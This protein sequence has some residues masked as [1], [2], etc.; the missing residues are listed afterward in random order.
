M[1]PSRR[2]LA[3]F[4]A[5]WA[6]LHC[7]GTL[8]AD[9][10]TNVPEAAGYQLVYTL[11]IPAQQGAYNTDAIPYSVNNAGM[12]PGGTFTR[13]A[14]YLEL[15]GSTDPTRPNGY[16]FVSFDRPA[17]FANGGS[18][19]V[20]SNGPNGSKIV[21]NTT[22]VNMNV[23]SNIQ[24]VITGTGLPGGKIE[25]WPGNY[26]VGANGVF[27][28]DDDG[29]NGGN[30][31]G[32]MQ[33]HNA[34]AGQT[35]IGYSDWGGNAPG[36]PSEIG[37]G[38]NTGA[39]DPDWTFSNTGTTYTVRS[40][41]I[42]VKPAANLVSITNP[43]F[44]VDPIAGP[45]APL[46]EFRGAAPTGWVYSGE[47]GQGLLAPDASEPNPFYNGFTPGYSGSKA[48]F[49]YTLST[50]GVPTLSQNLS[51]TLQANTTYGLS[52]QI[53]NR[54]NSDNWGGY[55]IALKTTSGTLV[56]EWVGANN[57]LAPFGQ[58]AR[59]AR[60]FTTGNNPP[61]LGQA[62]Q[63][64]IEQPNLNATGRYLEIDDVLLTAD[65]AP[66]RPAGTPIDVM[67]V[68][69]QSNAQG[70]QANVAALNS[71]NRHYADTPS[72]NAFIAYKQNAFGQ[73]LYISG[74]LGQLSSLGAGFAGNFDGFGPE[75]STGTDLAGRLPNKVAVI[76]FASGG[77][78]L[79]NHFKKTANVLYADLMATVNGGLAQLTAQGFAPTVKG[80]FW[81]QG[82]TDAL[83]GGTDATDAA[84][85]GANITQFVADVRADLGVPTLKFILTQI[86]PNM[87]AL[88]NQPGV[89]L[90]NQGM[91]NLATSDANVKYV[92]TSDITSGFADAIHYNGN[93]AITIGQRW[94]DAYSPPP[95]P[96]PGGSVFDRVPEASAEGYQ[97]LYELN[98]PTDAGYQGTTQIPYA[99]DNSLTAAAFDRV[100]YYL[101]LV[102]P[103]G[104]SRWV[105]A[106]MDAFTNVPKQLG[107]PHSVF[108][109]VKH[110]RLVANL[111][112]YSNVSGVVT[113]SSLDG[114]ALEMWPSNYNQGR[115]GL[116]YAGNGGTYDWDDSG[117]T[118]TD[119][120][121]GS[122][123]VHNPI[124]RQV[125]FAY[126]HWGVG[127]G[128]ADDIGIG[129][130]PSG[131]PDYTFSS[132][133]GNYSA[134]KLVIL[135]RPGTHV[136]FS[137]APKNRALYPR[138][139]ATGMATVPIAGT[140]GEGGY[141]SAILRIYR[142]GVFQ[143]ETVQPL[144]YT[145]TSAP[146]SFNPQIPAELAGYN[147]EVLLEKA[148]QRR[149][150]QRVTD[151]VAGDAYL[152]YGQSNGEAGSVFAGGNTTS[153]GYAGPW[154]RTFGQNADSGVATSNNLSWVSANGDG[155]G[156]GFVDPGAVGQW[157]IVVGGKIVA[158][159][160]I[161]VAILNGSRGGYTMPQL[162]KDRAM[163]DNLDD[164]ATVTRT[165][166]R[167]RYRAIQGGVAT[168][169]RA[170][171]FYQG[172]SENGNAQAHANGF[173]GLY[174]DW[175]TDYPALEHI[176][177]VQVRVGCGVT[178]NDVA[179]RQTQRSFGDTYAHTSV[180]AT[181]GITAHDGCH[182]RFIDGYEK[183]G[184][185]HFGEVARDLYG[186][187]AG[188]NIDALN[189]ATAEFTDA[190]HTQIRVTMRDPGATIN[191]PTD[192]L[193]DFA[194]AG[195]SAT[196][197]GRTVAGNAFT[198]QLSGSATG[199]VTLEY[200]GHAG[201]GAF[202][203]NGSGVG[204]L[205]FS[206]PVGPIGPLPPT[207]TLVSPASPQQANVGDTINIVATAANG[208]NGP[209]T[210]MVFRVNGVPKFEV[211]GNALNTT[212]QVPANG[213]HLLEV[214]AFDATNN[215]GTASVPVFV[216]QNASPGGVSGGL[217]IWLKAETGVIKDANGFV[218]AWQ[219][220]S[221][222][223]NHATQAMSANQPKL[224][225]NAFGVGAGVQ[226]DG[227][228]YLTSST[229]MPTGS[230]TKIVRFKAFGTGLSHNLISSDVGGTSAARDHAFFVP[231]LTPTIFHSGSTVSA[232]QPVGS[233]AAVV[234]ACTFDTA[235]NAANVYVDGV[236]R[237]TGNLDGPNTIASYQLGAFA[238]GNN[239]VGSL[240]EVIVYDHV[241]SAAERTAVFNYLDDKYRTPFGL[242]L[243]SYYGP[244]GSPT[245][246]APKDGLIAAVE[247]GLGLD[248]TQNNSGTT[249]LPAV[250]RNGNTVEVT[251]QRATDH[252]DAF[253]ELQFSAGL[254]TWITVSDTSIGVTG[255]VDT[256]RYTATVPPG[257]DAGFFR[258]RISVPQ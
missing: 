182:Y 207:V 130:Q 227:N 239:L 88:Q 161:P 9:V 14:Y 58:F 206:E 151:V 160:H 122:F 36:D 115:G 202:V 62:L 146:F 20:P 55:H 11:P 188:P 126:N 211:A 236:L 242:W 183:L 143:T 43:S 251:Y 86:N 177:E 21:T 28:Y 129:S 63:V 258:L 112:V 85:Y 127:D 247:Y 74:S 213:A 218:A 27:D 48:H 172:E 190:T 83:G 185:Y 69:G 173:S 125:I 107:L 120:G 245:A 137:Q 257:T 215:F 2:I 148:G 94:A 169:A 167:L 108:N 178:Q 90:V 34:A 179:L 195:T 246:D 212:W 12:W 119:A 253:V 17:V 180:M 140:E 250:V 156:S 67:I 57:N 92:P 252:P 71:G 87:P 158:D 198:L 131:E 65:P 56:G 42:L 116:F 95:P 196:I 19:G 26:A 244:S 61:G 101:E 25:F 222:N 46:F 103:D 219:D 32:S 7:P 254:A 76:K 142:S 165:Y 29:F 106:S 199:S 226:F 134:R 132:N 37:A 255:N 191:F 10:F 184:L 33:I 22:V 49:S 223:N 39:G 81:L 38:P 194:L 77:A 225:N 102:N 117:G 155:A 238:S 54:S 1:N 8:H 121:Y 157:A 208:S 4:A 31:H 150:V 152:F 135:T 166:N 193:G 203:T 104:S 105:Y 70:W 124:S 243:K 168:K 133:A 187:P 53:G 230:Y 68:S 45:N 214:I 189:P 229:G 235:G 192:A 224:A 240:A 174:A 216:G 73:P 248:P 249:R 144:T 75:L 162:Q 3:T 30:G 79:D 99:V 232:N 15:S 237:G 123:Q 128:A 149:L 60:K 241:L 201:G 13:V 91:Q 210:R 24:G 64:V 89:T 100:A 97:V 234:G 47:A 18:L 233:G 78:S 82:E 147:F 139:L 109:P 154:V 217:Q 93:Q 136:T 110:Q 52:V 41:Q 186:A 209:A 181:N 118:A 50:A 51:A 35:L 164:T 171:F 96:P 44:E 228:D 141:Q 84:A 256:R 231:N 175:Q 145:G 159:H 113:G 138:N 114:A 98:I 197:T 111:N 176:Y 220:Q 59:T 200:R 163:P 170:M 80:F 23:V 40:M 16:V 204:L 72:P 66:A 205:S 153:N 221:G 6:S 5:F